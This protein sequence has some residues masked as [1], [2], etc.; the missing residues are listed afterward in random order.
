MDDVLPRV[1]VAGEVS[2]GVAGFAKEAVESDPGV[3][4]DLRE[5][6]PGWMS[7][8]PLL[9]IDKEALQRVRGAR[10]SLDYN[11]QSGQSDI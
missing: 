8:D 5:V 6:L 1:P 2:Q 11:V 9:T 3:A 10:D 4:F 7:K